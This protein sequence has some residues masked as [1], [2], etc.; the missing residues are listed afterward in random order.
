MTAISITRALAKVK[1]LNDRIET[2]SS[3]LFIAT[4]TGGK[5]SSGKPVAEVETT[6]TANLQSVKDL[7]AERNKVKSAIVRSNAVT[8]VKVAGVE[9]T[10]AEAIERKGSIQLEVVLLQ[11]MKSQLA[12][13]TAKVERENVQVQARLDQLIQTTV[14]KDR[15]VDADEVEAITKPFEAKNKA[16]LLDPVDLAKVIAAME[17]EVKAFQDEVDMALSEVNATTFV[18]VE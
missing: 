10:V 8:K 3:Q 4:T 11:N 5:H 17:K 13:Q 9:M 12:I 6:I 7:I 1:S 18:E 2:G 14:G 15:K 16:A